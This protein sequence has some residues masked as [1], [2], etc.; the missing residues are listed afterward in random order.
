MTKA[1]H[2]TERTEVLRTLAALRTAGYV[3]A[4]HN[5]TNDGDR[6]FYS[7]TPSDE[8][9]AEDVFGVDDCRV[10]F[11]RLSPSPTEDGKGLLWVY[12]VLGNAEDGSEVLSDYSAPEGSPFTAALNALIDN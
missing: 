2:T 6:E 7:N 5:A 8:K 11:R 12:F 9:V 10:Y 1:Q 4:A 3:P